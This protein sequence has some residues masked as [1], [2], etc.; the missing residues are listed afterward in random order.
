MNNE[1]SFGVFIDYRKFGGP[2]KFCHRSE[3][4]CSECD[5]KESFYFPLETVSFCLNHLGYDE[6][7]GDKVVFSLE[8]AFEFKLLNE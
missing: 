7:L 3:K 8:E 4:S 1:E 6:R 5:W 2:L